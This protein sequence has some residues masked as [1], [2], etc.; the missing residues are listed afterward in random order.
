[1]K[2]ALITIITGQDRFYLSEFLLEKVCRCTVLKLTL[3]TF[4]QESE[5]LLGDLSKAQVDFG[6]NPEI[7]CKKFVKRC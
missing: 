6:W 3:G 4:S 7:R 1:M 2:R 5:P